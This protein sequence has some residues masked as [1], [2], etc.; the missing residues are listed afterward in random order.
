MD[1][2]NSTGMCLSHGPYLQSSQGFPKL[3]VWDI[4]LPQDLLPC[5]TLLVSWT[6]LPASQLAL[7]PIITSSLPFT[8]QQIWS[9]PSCLVLGHIPAHNTYIPQQCSNSMIPNWTFNSG[10][11]IGGGL[12]W[13]YA[14]KKVLMGHSSSVPS[15]SFHGILSYTSLQL[16]L[17]PT[18]TGRSSLL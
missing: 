5:N 9:Y 7:M 12:L 17:Q 16:Q 13:L 4:R 6:L 15:P 11:Y 14:G 2:V 1:K 3:T 18:I 8:L 10:T